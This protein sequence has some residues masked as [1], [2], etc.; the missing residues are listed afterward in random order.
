MKSSQLSPQVKKLVEQLRKANL[1]IEDRSALVS[2]IL[3]KV[4]ALPIGDVLSIEGDYISVNGKQMDQEQ[5]IHFREA[6]ANLKDNFARKVLSEQIRYKAIEQG[7]MKSTSTDT[8]MF[9]KAALWCL[10]EYE[11]LLAKITNI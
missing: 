11:I 4:D 5:V 2:C 6:C 10:N 3:E 8:L 7:I 9:S 1:S